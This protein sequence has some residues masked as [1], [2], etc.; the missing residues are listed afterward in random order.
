MAVVVATQRLA[1]GVRIVA[2]GF[3]PEDDAF[4]V[5]PGMPRTV[6]LW[7][8]VDG[9]SLEGAKVTALNLIGEAP[10]GAPDMAA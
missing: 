7:P 10:I 1:W 4:V 9:A 2:P 5:V 6:R 8:T 3:R